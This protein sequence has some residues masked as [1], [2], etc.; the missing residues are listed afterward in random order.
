MVLILFIMNNSQ[1]INHRHFINIKWPNLTNTRKKYHNCKTS[2][3][4]W[5]RNVIPINNISIISQIRNVRFRLFSFSWIT[6]TKSG[7]TIRWTLTAE[8][9]I[10]SNRFNRFRQLNSFISDHLIKNPLPQL[11]Q[12]FQ[13]TT[14]RL[15]GSK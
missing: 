13:A 12:I 14:P 7:L 1:L 6:Q 11:W 8:P 9:P 15:E 5:M 10:N 3:K 2:N 4:D